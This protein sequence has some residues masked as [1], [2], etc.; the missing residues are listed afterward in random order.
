[1]FHNNLQNGHFIDKAGNKSQGNL[2]FALSY[3]EI[4]SNHDGRIN[5][6]SEAFSEIIATSQ[7]VIKPYGSE[8]QVFDVSRNC[9]LDGF[10]EITGGLDKV[11]F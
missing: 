8:F 11:H 5:I 7:N 9:I 6:L 4:R 1:M 3:D 10:G 2:A